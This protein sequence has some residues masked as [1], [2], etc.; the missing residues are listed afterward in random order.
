MHCPTSSTCDFTLCTA[1]MV[2]VGA[3]VTGASAS[4]PCSTPVCCELLRAYLVGECNTEAISVVSLLRVRVV[5]EC[6][7]CATAEY[8]EVCA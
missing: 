4:P 6:D 2:R 5:V 1:A 3:A 7:D 8:A